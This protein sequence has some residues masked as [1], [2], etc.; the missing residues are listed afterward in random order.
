MDQTLHKEAT[1]RVLHACLAVLQMILTVEPAREVAAVTQDLLVSQAPP[2]ASGAGEAS[3]KDDLAGFKLLKHKDPELRALGAR[4]LAGLGDNAA[5]AIPEL[6][7]LLGDER[8]AERDGLMFSRTLGKVASLAL[9]S[10]GPKAVPALAD[11]MLTSLEK[12][13]RI[14]AA[15]TLIELFD[16]SDQKP[17]IFQ[18][19]NRAAA[20]P[21]EAMRR[22]AVQGLG[23]M[24][25][26]AKPALPHLIEIVK[27]DPSEWV[28]FE[29]VTSLRLIDPKGDRVVHDL[30]D[31]L[32]R[33]KGRCRQSLRSWKSRAKEQRAQKRQSMHL[34]SWDPRPG[35][36]CPRCFARLQTM[37][38]R[39]A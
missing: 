38:P 11:A 15:S 17:L 21:E 35:R 9:E 10:I 7:A 26:M 28:R 39:F 2:V 5:P 19:L 22:V 24:G 3:S 32:P 8:V 1:M 34:L 23:K 18:R 13:A 20:D 33:T 14:L 37:R 6:I 31:A 30:T 36:P 4:L 29:A 25:P 27:G 16:K 12:A